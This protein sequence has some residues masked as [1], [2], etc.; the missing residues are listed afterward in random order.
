MHWQ[1]NL[2]NFFTQYSLQIIGAIIIFCVGLFVARWVGN[3]VQGWLSKQ[4]IELPIQSLMVRLVRLLIMALVL[5][6]VL[7]KFGVQIAPLIAG[8]GVAGVGIGFAMQGVLGNI[9]AG[10]TIIFTKPYRVG[11]YIEL[12]GVYGQVTTIELFSTVLVHADQSR[13]V[14]PNRKVVGE[15]MHNYGAIRQLD[16][17]VG[18]AYSTNMPKALGTIQRI[19]DANPRVL[20]E[21]AP[22]VGI[23]SLGDSSINISIKPW[24]KVPDFGAAQLEIYQATVEQFRANQIEIPF[25]QRELRVLD[26]SRVEVKSA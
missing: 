13:V 7:D 17:T 12:L 19:L 1:D 10:L 18:V 25:P 5:V 2:I 16:L 26:G 4:H 15:I 6:L 14:I 24:V 11:E 9:I 20:K 8:I 23:S 3:L 22:V 21:P